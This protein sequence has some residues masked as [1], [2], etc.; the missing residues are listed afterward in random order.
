MSHS[1][2]NPD[3]PTVSHDVDGNK[4]RYHP[5]ASASLQGWNQASRLVDTWR[6]QC[7]L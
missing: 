5:P 3:D 4:K 2:S 7:R 1:A 6:V